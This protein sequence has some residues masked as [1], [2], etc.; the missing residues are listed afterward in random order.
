M[1]S[2]QT[3]RRQNRATSPSRDGQARRERSR[4]QILTQADPAKIEKSADAVVLK[5]GSC[6][7]LTTEAGDVPF[8][9]PHAF[10]LYLNDCR[11]LDAYALTLNGAAPTVLSALAMRGFETQHYLTNPELPNIGGARVIPKNTVAIHRHR[12]IRGGVVHELQSIRNYGAQEVHLRLELRFRSKFQDV[13]VVKRFV[14]KSPG[15]VKPV[16]VVS[17]TRVELSYEG[18]DGRFRATTIV[19]SPRPDRLDPDCATFEIAL[20]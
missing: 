8:S 13:F 4:E 17:D 9:L 18:D 15:T 3:S 1:P 5:Q 20:A 10:G 7:F 19:F 12:L 16:D 14:A 11:F 2:T 6:F